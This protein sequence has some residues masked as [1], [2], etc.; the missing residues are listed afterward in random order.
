M[1]RKANNLCVK[2][3]KPLDRK[4]ALCSS[5]LKIQNEYQN[6][7]RHWLSEHHICPRCGQNDLVGD[8]KVCLECAA[9]AYATAMASRDRLGKEHYNQMH[10]A[11][12]RNAT[13]ERRENGICYRCGKRKADYGYKT[14]GVCRDKMRRSRE[15]RAK[16]AKRDMWV[17]NGLCFFCGQPV[18]E[19]FKVCQ[20]H[21]DMNVEKARSQKAVTARKEMSKQ[22][23]LY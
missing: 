16:T 8:E 6:D 15:T 11:W 17:R 9:K 1:R 7:T 14:C 22:G 12:A 19:G 23:I 4:G 21:Y 18:V 3:G 13:K 10:N 2:C 20:K 5:C